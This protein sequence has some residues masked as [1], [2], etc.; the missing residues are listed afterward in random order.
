MAR[1]QVSMDD[2]SPIKAEGEELDRCSKGR[3]QSISPR[4]EAEI[5]YPYLDSEHT[6]YISA[7]QSSE[8]EDRVES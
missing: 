6:F 4:S 1:R 8:I 5:S 3:H 2:V 7:D